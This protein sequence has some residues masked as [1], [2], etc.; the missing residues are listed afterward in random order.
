MSSHQASSIFGPGS[1]PRNATSSDE[2]PSPTNFG[3]NFALPLFGANLSGFT[4]GVTGHA[5]E[6]KVGSL[7]SGGDYG[8]EGGLLTT[9]VVV[10][11]FFVLRRVTPAASATE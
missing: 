1:T 10:L 11:L 8:P 9:L 2:I 3:W 7:W 6:W 5:L 4:M